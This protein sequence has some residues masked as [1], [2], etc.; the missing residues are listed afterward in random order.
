MEGMS[1]NDVSADLN[2]L[3]EWLHVAPLK[4]KCHEKIDFIIEHFLSDEI[5][6]YSLGKKKP[7]WRYSYLYYNSARSIY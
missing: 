2:S 6:I 3:L 5:P 4:K 1:Q 7:D